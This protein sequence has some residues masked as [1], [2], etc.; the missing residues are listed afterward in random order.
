MLPI[1]HKFEGHD[2]ESAESRGGLASYETRSRS[3]NR[4]WITGMSGLVEIRSESYSHF[5]LSGS[6]RRARSGGPCTS[7]I[8]Q[9]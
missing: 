7:I 5:Q 2:R 9:R 6:Y 1:T 8:R 3:K 4:T